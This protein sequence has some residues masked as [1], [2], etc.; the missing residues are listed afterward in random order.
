MTMTFFSPS[1]PSIS[2]S[3]CGH[4]R[5]LDVGGDAGAAGAEQR[6]HLVEEHDDRHVLVGLFLGLDEDLA[7][8]ALGLAD[9]L[10][11]QLGP[12]DVEE[13]ALDL[14]AALLGDLLGEVVGHGLGDHG[15]AAAGRAVEQHALGRRELVLL[16]VVGVEVRQLDGV[17]DRLDLV[18]EA[19]DLLVADVRHFLERE[20]FDLALGQLLEQVADLRASIRRWSPVFRRRLAERIGDDAD[21]LL[22]G[23]QRDDRALGVELLLEDDDVALDLVAGRLDDVQALVEDQLLAGLERLDLDGG[24]QVDL[25][26]AA[27]RQ[28][29]DRARPRWRR[30]T[31]RTSRAARRACRPLPSAR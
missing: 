5:G 13:E 24:V 22:V 20:I 16:V 4:D 3:S 19:A 21:L 25:H 29:V 9:V 15:L 27:L 14:L 8:L 1:T 23:A 2:A 7:D 11:Q 6:V 30:D 31:R 18:A 17:L 12:L 10:V 28:D 26:L